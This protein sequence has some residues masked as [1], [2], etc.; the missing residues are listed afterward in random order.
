MDQLNE[1]VHQGFSG[2][3]GSL[4]CRNQQGV[5]RYRHDPVAHEHLKTRQKRRS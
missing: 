5:C 1:P 4:T 3:Q 2:L